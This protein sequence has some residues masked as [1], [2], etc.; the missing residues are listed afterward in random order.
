MVSRDQ[1]QKLKEPFPKEELNWRVGATTPDKKKG[2]ALAYI[3]ARAVMD[4]LDEVCG[5]ENWQRKYQQFGK[6]YVCEIGINIEGVGWVWKSDG[7]SET[8][9][10]A[11]KG[12]LSDAFKRAAVSWGIGR[13]L[14]KLGAIWVPIKQQGNSY[15]IDTPPQ[16]PSWALPAGG[17]QKIEPRE[18]SKQSPTERSQSREEQ[19]RNMCEND[20]Q[21]QIVVDFLKFEK[22][23]DSTV[24]S[25]NDLSED[26]YTDLLKMLTNARKIA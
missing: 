9:F 7:A 13:Y 19:I 22:K 1:L 5:P 17:G 8:D 11:T 14:Y 10:E 16:I 25:V 12:G 18:R 6:D 4:R 15:A 23:F 21:K 20:E 3:D 24:R 2:L 26:K